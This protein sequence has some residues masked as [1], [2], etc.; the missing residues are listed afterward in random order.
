[1]VKRLERD[2]EADCRAIVTAAGGRPYK[3]VSPGAVGV[4]DQLCFLP[5]GVFAVAEIKRI[6]QPLRPRQ[7]AHYTTLQSLGF[8]VRRVTTT[9]EMRELIDAAHYW[10]RNPHREFPTWPPT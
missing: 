1:M 8:V 10:R 9:D 4:P 6:G 2:I 3:W 7:R 5:D